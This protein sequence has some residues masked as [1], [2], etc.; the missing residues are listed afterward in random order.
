MS[1][2]GADGPARNVNAG[3][4]PRAVDAVVVGAGPAGC[5]AAT[6]LGRAGR[7]VL[8]VDRGGVPR[9]RLCTH[10][11]MPSAIP[12]LQELGVLDAVLGAG[13]QAWWGVRLFM[14]GTRIE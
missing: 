14:E 5:A 1:G 12:V 6:V 11:L 9:P 10:A 2:V 4:L 7:R 13:A 3:D 8:L